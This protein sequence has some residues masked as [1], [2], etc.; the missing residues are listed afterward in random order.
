MKVHLSK[1]SSSSAASMLIATC[2]E[3]RNKA[4]VWHLVT[5]TYATHV[6]LQEFYEGIVDLT[7]AYA[8]SYIGVYGKPGFDE[9]T[10]SS[11][12]SSSPDA[13]VRSLL[14][15]IQVNRSECGMTT[16]LQNQIDEMAALCNR[17]LYK[18]TLV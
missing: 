2:F 6:A 18:F 3:A 4:H 14:E 5:S 13:V 1:A 11:I 17:I 8:E 9:Y 12:D 16:E 15:H 10:P 7:D